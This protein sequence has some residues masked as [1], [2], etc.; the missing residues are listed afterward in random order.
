MN[1]PI[2]YSEF[3]KKGKV[4]FCSEC[5]EYPCALIKNLDKRY[6]SSYGIHVMDS[7]NAIK[8]QGLE[9]FVKDQETDWTCSHCGE[10]LCMH[11]SECLHC[12]K[13]R[14]M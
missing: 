3:V 14:R 1:C 12:G 9:R 8:K 2:K 11:K 10:V 5:S 13:R 6:R 7:L 4:D